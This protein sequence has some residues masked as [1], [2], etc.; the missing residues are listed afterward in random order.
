[1]R[2]KLKQ[3]NHVLL[4]VTRSGLELKMAGL[5]RMNLLLSFLVQECRENAGMRSGCGWVDT[6]GFTTRKRAAKPDA[7]DCTE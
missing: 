1:M 7:A 3:A 2:A 5:L 4:E 6:D